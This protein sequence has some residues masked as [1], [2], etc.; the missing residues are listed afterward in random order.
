MYT[1]L[2]TTKWSVIVDCSHVGSATASF[3]DLV[4]L[5][6][7]ATADVLTED[8]PLPPL[9]MVT[10]RSENSTNQIAELSASHSLDRNQQ[11]KVCFDDA[12]LTSRHLFRGGGGLHWIEKWSSYGR[13]LK[14]LWYSVLPKIT[15]KGLIVCQLWQC[16]NRERSLKINFIGSFHTQWVPF[17]CKFTT[18]VKD[19]RHAW[20]LLGGNSSWSHHLGR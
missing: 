7:R 1:M 12:S 2:S 13:I 10:V 8:Q 16:R 4:T 5:H 18:L 15:M 11:H 3:K 19:S 9:D 17:R 6:R 20:S 14:H